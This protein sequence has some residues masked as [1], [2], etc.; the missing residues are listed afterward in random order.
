VADE[1]GT[2][3]PAV[4]DNLYSALALAQ[5]AGDIDALR[6][7]RAIATALG[8]GALARGLG[9]EAENQAA[10]VVLRAE[11]ALGS[12]LLQI[13]RAPRGPKKGSFTIP[14]RRSNR[15]ESGEER[16]RGTTSGPSETSLD[17]AITDLGV[18]AS[19]TQH[20][21]WLAMLPEDR[22]EQLLAEHRGRGERIAKVNFYQAARPKPAPGWR[23][24]AFAPP[25]EG[26]APT[27]AYAEFRKAAMAL[28]ANISQVPLD[29]MAEV[30]LL[31]KDLANAYNVE[32]M[33]RG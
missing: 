28:I 24:V 31:I 15:A 6:D 33:K 5:E 23:E 13:P 3:L 29:E 30:A 25:E 1:T 11:R 27:P 16:V 8:R 22:F 20:W 4:K 32:R 19:T 14:G 9:I 21:Q 10:E 17:K 18:A 12:V 26:G 2:N 7:V